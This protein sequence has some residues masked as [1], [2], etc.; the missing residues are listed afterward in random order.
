MELTYMG[1]CPEARGEKLG[2][3]LIHEAIACARRSGSRCLTLAVDCRNQPAYRLYR[4]VGFK[5]FL[6][7]TVLYRSAHWQ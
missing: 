6:T 1:L 7:R 4:A 2:K 3:Y 5:N